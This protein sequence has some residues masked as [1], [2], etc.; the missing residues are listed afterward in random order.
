MKVERLCSQRPIVNGQLPF[1]GYFIMQ[2]QMYDILFKFYLFE[3]KK[4]FALQFNVLSD[5]D[6]FF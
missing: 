4:V 6:N 1:L 5:V 3:D 2:I